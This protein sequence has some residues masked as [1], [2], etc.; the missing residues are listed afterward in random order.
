ML[1]VQLHSVDSMEYDNDKV[2]QTAQSALQSKDIH[3]HNNKKLPMTSSLSSLHTLKYTKLTI[4]IN[5]IILLYYGTVGETIT[6]V[7]HG[8]AIL[9]GLILWKIALLI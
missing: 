7:A 2:I 4:S 9:L 8:C 5:I 1:L 6:M 3:D